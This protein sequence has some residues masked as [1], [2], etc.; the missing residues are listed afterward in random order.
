MTT[1][2]KAP[3]RYGSEVPRIYTPP[4]RELTPETSLGFACIEFAEEV[5]MM[6]LYPWQAWLLIH[7]LELLPDG[8]GELRFR[9]VVVLASRQNG[10]CLCVATPMLTTSGWST[11]GEL[12]AGDQV[13]HPDG[14][15]TAVTAAH[16]VHSDHRCYEMI[17]TDGRS[18]VADAEHLWTVQDRRKQ[19]VRKTE[20]GRTYSLEWET[21]TTEQLLARGLIRQ[22]K[23]PGRGTDFAFR[24]PRQH[25]IVSK[26]VELPLDPYLLGFWLGDGTVGEPNLTIGTADLDESRQLLEDAGARIQSVRRTNTSWTVRITQGD[27]RLVPLL[28]DLGVLRD[29]HIPARYLTAGTEQRLALLQGLMDTD[30]SIFKVGTGTMRAEFCSVF[31]QLAE[32]VLFLVRSLGWRA[33]DD[34]DASYLNG[35]QKRD[36]HRICF[37]PQQ[38]ERIPF[39]MKRKADRIQPPRSRSGERHSVSIRSITPVESRPVRCI[40][41]DRPDGLYL[42]GRDLVVTHNSSIS[43]VLSLFFMYVL[44]RALVIGTAQDLDVAEEIWQGAVDL[45]EETPELAEE[46]ERIVKVNGK[47]AIELKTGQRYKVKS[48]SRRAGRGLSGDLILLDELRE[49]QSWDAWGA[50]TKTTMARKFALVVA[51]SNAGDATSVVLRHLRK[52]AHLAL[53]D[54]DGINAEVGTDDSDAPADDTGIEIEEDDSLGIFEWSA[55]PGR[56]IHDRDAWAQA[57][58]SLGWAITE[59]TLTSAARTDPEWVFRTECMCEWSDGS[60]EGPFPPGAWEACFDESSAIVGDVVACVSVTKDRSRSHIAV[61]GYRADGKV[62]VEIVASAVGTDWVIDWLAHRVSTG[63]LSRIALQPSGAPVS[64]LRDA[65][66][67]AGLPITDWSGPDQG[68]GTGMFYDLVRNFELRHLAQPVLDVAAATAAMRPAGD[69]WMWDLRKSQTDV[70]PLI[71]ATGA[72]WLLLPKFMEK[73]KT[74]QVHSWDEELWEDLDA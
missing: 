44:A 32:D 18:V 39:R 25:E 11:M 49:H 59:R 71:A 72:V 4:L 28:R 27:E 8:D 42:A 69:A 1:A 73:P 40:T 65:A 17:T 35:V 55:H 46:L 63:T 67:V 29:K 22:E 38:G 23:R 31:P 50:I 61:A 26:P 10:K 2:P 70:A 36:R 13:F 37:T 53:G 74:P 60:L 14:H 5:L 21:L 16:D 9:T 58:P 15:P 34:L 45:I 24:L 57:N 19:K 56:D 33:S 48:S 6:S 64:S 7:M 43:I 20:S 41:V 62:H 66:E 30:G 3:P 54:P 68:R 47:K 52:M 51:L 12:K